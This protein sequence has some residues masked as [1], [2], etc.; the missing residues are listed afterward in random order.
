[1]ISVQIWRGA[2]SGVDRVWGLG[3]VENENL[4]PLLN[5]ERHFYVRNE[6]RPWVE[7]A[8]TRTEIA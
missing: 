6:D 5:G 8:K 4:T 2:V 3:A 7:Y 1:M